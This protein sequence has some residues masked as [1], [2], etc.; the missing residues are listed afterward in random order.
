MSVSDYGLLFSILFIVFVLFH[1]IHLADYEVVRTLQTQYNLAIDE[2]VEAA[3]YDVVEE[4]S[5]L[6]LIMNE[7]EVIHRF[8]QSLFINLGIMEQPAKKELCKFYVPYILLVE[9]DGIIPYQQE[10]AGKSEEIVFQT[11]KK[12][13]YQ[14]SMENKE[15]LRATL[16]DYVYYDNLVTGKHMEG[17]YRDIVSEL[18]EKLRW[19]YDIFDKKKRELVIDTIKS[20]TSECINHQNQIARKY[21]IEYK[22]TLPLIEY[23]AWYRTIQDVSMIALFQGYPF[24][25]SRT[26]IFNRAA[27]GG[28]R[29]AKQKRET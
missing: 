25:N 6:D 27:L 11:R 19:R 24:G 22:F 9:K 12:I 23:E 28:A 21:G 4:D 7:E 10:I 15:I 17:D 26:G 3:L 13:H 29:I 14:W 2:A 8:F 5:G 18:P 1:V 16:T 20:C